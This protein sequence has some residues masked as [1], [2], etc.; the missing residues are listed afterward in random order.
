LATKLLQGEEKQKA[1]FQDPSFNY[2]KWKA[3]QS[4]PKK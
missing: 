2:Q 1:V 3:A 4:A